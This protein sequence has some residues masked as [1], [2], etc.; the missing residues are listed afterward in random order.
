MATLYELTDKQIKL[1]ELAED[2]V[3]EPEVFNDTMEAITGAF[4]DKAV[5]YVQV[6]K[7]IEA[8]AEV[9]DAEIKRLS[10]RKASYKKNAQLIKTRLVDAMK[11]T[12][13]LKLKTPL[14]TIWV[15]DTPS[16]KIEGDD[17]GKVEAQY[18]HEERKLI[19]DKKAIAAA[20]KDGKEVKGATLV[21]SSSLRTR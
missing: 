4:E 5:A 10:E 8:D 14:Y 7:Q 6:A 1:L 21:Y 2:G 3:I 15:Q 13:N 19:A 17:A 16:V 9:I 11:E 12:E 18:V 20:L